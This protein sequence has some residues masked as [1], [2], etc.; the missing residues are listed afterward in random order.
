MS[1]LDPIGRREVR[2]LLLSLRAKNKTVFFSSHI[3][4]DV[5]AICDR[6]AILNRGKLLK[7]GSVQELTGDQGDYLEI[8]AVGIDP[9]SIHVFTEHLPS[10]ASVT[11][12]PSGVNLG[13]R[14]EGDVDQAIRLIHQ[15]G[16]KLV[17][18]NPRRASLED[19]FPTQQSE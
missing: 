4:S 12:T 2:D 11:A 14:S 17:S 15:C 1:G 5:E 6:A 3:L 10:D 7:C 18:I 19:L 13:I 9:S 16:G 8:V